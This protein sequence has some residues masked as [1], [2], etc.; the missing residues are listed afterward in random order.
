MEQCVQL[1]RPALAV[2]V[3]S[4]IRKAGIHPSAVTYGF[5][6]KA[7]LEGKWPS[8]KRRWNVLK[9]VFY[10]CFYLRHLQQQSLI[11]GRKMTIVSVE[12][13]EANFHLLRHSISQGSD[14]SINALDVGVEGIEEPAFMNPESRKIYGRLSRGSVYR[15]SSLSTKQNSG[16]YAFRGDSFYIA[17]KS[18]LWK[19]QEEPVQSG[20]GLLLPFQNP[21][22]GVLHMQTHNREDGACVKVGLYSCSQCP[23]CSNVIYDE[24]IMVCWSEEAEE[25]NI[26]CPYCNKSCV[27]SLTVNITKVCMYV[28]VYI[29]MYVCTCIYMYVCMYMYMYVYIH[30]CYTACMNVHVCVYICMYICMYVCIYVCMYVCMYVC[31]LHVCMYV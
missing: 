30:V 19:T 24:E 5:Y 25:Y 21:S 1:G 7:L 12:E 22:Q 15:L 26:T 10:A 18:P 6:N 9:I 11:D 3:Y 23:S 31:T 29:C 17:D 4:E 20:Q 28:H 13:K 16:D 14:Y 27:P 2:K 8:V